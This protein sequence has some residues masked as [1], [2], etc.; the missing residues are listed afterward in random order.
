[1]LHAFPISVWQGLKL[2]PL[3]SPEI[4][5]WVGY[6]ATLSLKEAFPKNEF[7]GEGELSLADVILKEEREVQCGPKASRG[8]TE[9]WEF[10]LGLDVAGREACSDTDTNAIFLTDT[11]QS[12]PPLVWETTH[13]ESHFVSV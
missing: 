4:V 5:S 6:T 9:G 7:Y 3:E 1:M 2:T 13:I 10:L 12:I 11:V 8:K